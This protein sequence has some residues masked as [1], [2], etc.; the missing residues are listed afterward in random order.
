VEADDRD[1]DPILARGVEQ[2]PALSTETSLPSTNVMFQ[3]YPFRQLFFEVLRVVV[4]LVFG[5]AVTWML[6]SPFFHKRPLKVFRSL[7]LLT[8]NLERP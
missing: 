5:L 4:F 6:I 2:G 3:S 7:P 8:C 1:V